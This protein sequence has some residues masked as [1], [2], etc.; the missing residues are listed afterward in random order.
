M[1]DL[2]RGASTG[3][4]PIA[5]RRPIDRT[6]TIRRPAPQTGRV[7]R[8]QKEVYAG[9][10]R[11]LIGLLFFTL[12]C[13][14]EEPQAA[15]PS[16]PATHE[17]SA[18]PEAAP[19]PDEELPLGVTPDEPAPPRRPAARPSG[20]SIQQTEWVTLFVPQYLRISCHPRFFFRQCFRDV[21]ESECKDSMTRHIASCVSGG[22]NIPDVIG[23]AEESAALGTRVGACAGSRYETAFTEAGRRIDSA[24][25]NDPSNWQAPP[26]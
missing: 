8:S 13:S 15:P 25:C 19:A 17:P 18:T 16:V 21:A 7:R 1:L 9:S 4:G 5:S 10:M 12:A 20:G 6:G 23:S 26:E 2:Q 3:V 11:T 22:V 14:G 24:L